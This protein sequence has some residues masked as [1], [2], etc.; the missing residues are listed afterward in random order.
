MRL[1]ATVLFFFVLLLSCTNQ[2]IVEGDRLRA[3]YMEEFA[4]LTSDNA[5]G[6]SPL[7]N[8]LDKEGLAVSGCTRKLF[9]VKSTGYSIAGY[10][11]YP[12]NPRGTVYVLHGYSSYA[13]INHALFEFLA[14]NNW[15]VAAMDLPGHGL[16]SGERG[17]IKDFSEYGTV[18]NDF[19]NATKPSFPAPFHIVAHS[20]GCSAVFELLRNGI[21]PF[22]RYVFCSPLIRTVVYK[23]AVIG[24]ALFGWLSPDFATPWEDPFATSK[25]TRGWIDAL[26]KW[27]E[28]IQSTPPINTPVLMLFGTRDQVT[29]WEYNKDFLERKMPFS[30]IEVYE[31]GIHE[32]FVDRPEIADRVY[33]RLESYLET[34][35]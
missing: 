2:K 22:E 33:S 4:A 27:N 5:E 1:K 15:A 20:T 16:S 24:N 9:S 34:G 3:G 19:T 6:E 26:I 29:D 32:L 13:G 30:R 10:G 23:Q 31:K 25:I 35:K 12:A 11:F 14:A 28:K 8:V 7:Y 18:L 17:G 21:S